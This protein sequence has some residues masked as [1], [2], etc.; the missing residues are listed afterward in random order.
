MM[1][2]SSNWSSVG[3]TFALTEGFVVKRDEAHK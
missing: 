3:C 2:K 1:A